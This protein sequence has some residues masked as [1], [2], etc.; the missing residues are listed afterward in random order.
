MA[1]FFS[2][3]IYLLDDFHGLGIAFNAGDKASEQYSSSL[4]REEKG[5]STMRRLPQ[6]RQRATG[7]HRKSP[8]SIQMGSEEVLSE[9]EP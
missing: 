7:A 4:Q 2:P 3:N 1:S 8:T 5:K 6:S 9:A